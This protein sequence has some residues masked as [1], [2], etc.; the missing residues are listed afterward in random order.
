MRHERTATFSSWQLLEKRGWMQQKSRPSF[1]QQYCI[2][3]IWHGVSFGLTQHKIRIPVIKFSLP[4][5]HLSWGKTILLLHNECHR[6]HFQYMLTLLVIFCI[7]IA[8]HE[9]ILMLYHTEGSLTSANRATM[10]TRASPAPHTAPLL[11]L[12]LLHKVSDIRLT[13]WNILVPLYQNSPCLSVHHASGSR[14]MLHAGTK[15]LG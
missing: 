7:C 1:A 5:C 11:S 14:E 12:C 3:I 10:Q 15:W 13:Y 4:S 8:W 2:S 9:T 6:A